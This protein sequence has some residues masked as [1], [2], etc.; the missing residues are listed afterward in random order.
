MPPESFTVL[1]IGDDIKYNP[2][3]Y[4]TFSSKFKI[5]QPSLE[6]RHR[7]NFI[8][9]LKEKRW[10]DFH[11]VFR[12]F[13]NSGGE[14]GRWDQ[15]ELVPHLPKTC[16]IFASAGAGY[17]WADIPTL[18]SHGI[19]YCN[20][21]RASSEAV[22][23]M[24]I[25]HLLSVFRNLIW[26]A[27]AAKSGDVEQFKDAHKNQ[28]ETAYNP[29]GHTVGII[30]LGNIGYTIAE[31]AFRGFGMKVL[32]HDIVRKSEVQESAVQ[33]TYYPELD[34]MLAVAD[35]VVLATPFFGSILITTERLAKFKRGSRFVNIARG[36][37]VDEDALV[38]ALK[39]G[40]IFAAGL[41]VHANEPHVHQ[42]LTKMRNVTLTCH[43]AGGAWDTA[44]GFES[45]AMENI[46]A[47]LLNGQALTP[48]NAHLI[49]MNK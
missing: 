11:A 29:R 6:E 24:A 35:C 45:L 44:S 17:D 9:A 15:A 10:G 23:D 8:S 1:H 27:E 13:W 28:K 38:S 12:P 48:V 4:K 46:E 37:L 20:G 40:H 5:I 36:T 43:N 21:A 49:E 31:K 33:A 30:G 32:Y 26:S 39:S 7:S 16:K 41:D 25:W 34:E 47:F 42:E 3:L 14:M 19:V 22:A 2:D 18:S